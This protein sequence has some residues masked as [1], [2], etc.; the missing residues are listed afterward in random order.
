MRFS[1]SRFWLESRRGFTVEIRSSSGPP[2]RN[3]T[4]RPA[5]CR[6]RGAARVAWPLLSPAGVKLALALALALVAC[7][8]DADP[9]PGEADG[10]TD[11]DLPPPGTPIL[12]R[13]S[14][15]THSCEVVDQPAEVAGDTHGS[16]IA[17]VGDG[18]LVVRAGWGLVG[19][20]DYRA[21]L[22]VTPATFSPMALGAEAYRTTAPDTLRLPALAA[23]GDGALLAWIAGDWNQKLMVARLDAAGHIVGSAAPL[24]DADGA[25]SVAIDSDEA[26]GR[27]LWAD[28]ALH[29]QRV[30]SDGAPRGDAVTIRT[31]P[32]SGA[33]LAP[34][35]DGGTVVVWT[36][37]EADA[38]VY[39]ALLDGDG[40]LTAGPLRVSGA[41]PEFTFVA[42]PAVIAAGDEL[43]VAWSEAY[44]RED[45]DGDPGT[46][47]PDG[48]SVVRVARV[49]GDGRRV[50]ALERLQAIEDEIIHIQPAFTT[51]DDGVVALS[52]SRGTF[53]AVC[54]GCVSDNTRRLV[55]LDPHDLVPLGAVV[56][57]EGVTGFSTAAM[58]ASAGHLVHLLGLDYHAIS[59]VALARTRCGPAS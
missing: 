11:P 28:A 27:V 21:I 13:A 45:V 44:W 9:D 30:T 41:L 12:E 8:S 57:M 37:L 1:E 6:Y 47:D 50:L 31:A 22:A 2:L 40:A 5:K 15:D 26:S 39:L 52:W 7:G 49:S 19:D 16:A 18:P 51:I 36:E 23:A 35:A 4:G 43:L 56:E 48:H 20:D 25:V 34:G 33:V 55:L 58:I 3:L 14:R 46:W 29:L 32:M 17:Q 59:N 42:A 10:G 38:G 24:A 54:A 53:I